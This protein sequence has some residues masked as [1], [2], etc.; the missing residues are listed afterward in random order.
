MHALQLYTDLNLLERCMLVVLLIH[1]QVITHA[2][3][4]CYE[5]YESMHMSAVTYNKSSATVSVYSTPYNITSALGTA[6]YNT[7]QSTSIN[8]LLAR[9]YSLYHAVE[10]VQYAL[11]Q[12][13]S[14]DRP[15]VCNV[16]TLLVQ[17]Y[18]TYSDD[19]LYIAVDEHTGALT[20]TTIACKI[21]MIESDTSTTSATSS[22]AT[23]PTSTNMSF[24]RSHSSS[25]T[26]FDVLEPARAMT[27]SSDGSDS[28]TSSFH[29]ADYTPGTAAYYKVAMYGIV[30]CEA[31]TTANHNTIKHITATGRIVT[32]T[33][34][35]TATTL[36]SS[37]D[38]S[39]S[40]TSNAD[41]DMLYKDIT[42]LRTFSRK[43]ITALVS[44][45]LFYICLHFITHMYMYTYIVGSML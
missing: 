7:I 35:T 10:M 11:G 18:Y 3:T 26:Q 45:T 34:I 16:Q 8:V 30:D 36:K 27:S 33:P 44:H 28:D 5:Q 13:I 20:V 1:T 24:T 40:G 21:T 6:V 29:S 22:A 25:S 4:D 32:D 14:I 17:G 12:H 23:S 31:A 2:D 39:T 43:E 38:D 19:D 42:T 15:L 37:K 41:G 9:S